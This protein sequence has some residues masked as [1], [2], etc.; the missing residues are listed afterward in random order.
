M[1]SNLDFVRSIWSGWARGDLDPNKW[2]HP[3]IAFEEPD[4]PEPRSTEG[5]P[6]LEERIRVFVDT[7]KDWHIDAEVCRELDD[8][9]VLVLS[10]ITGRDG[11]RGMQVP[12]ARA[13]LLQIE[14]EKVVRYI[15][16][17]NRDDGLADFGLDE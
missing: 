1:P 4:G 15:T 17:W 7:W 5:I 6:A 11:A 13:T 14:D 2:A 9:R 12:Q 8:G 3:D 10:R 16:Y